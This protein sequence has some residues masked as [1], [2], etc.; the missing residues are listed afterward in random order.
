MERSAAV[1]VALGVIGAAI[2]AT[3]PAQAAQTDSATQQ[4]AGNNFFTGAFDMLQSNLDNVA[5][6]PADSLSDANVRAFLMLIRTGEG[7]AD[8]AGYSRLF[9]G[10]QFASYAD[11]PR[12]F[13]PFGST[14]STAAGAYQILARTWDEIAAKYAL[15]DFSPASQDLAAV[16]LIKRRGAL[17]DVLAGRFRTAIQKCANE[18]ASLPGSPYGQPTLSMS[19][20]ALVL[21]NNGGNATETIA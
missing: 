18:W 19:K 5:A 11:H 6:S 8:A 13:V 9:G 15:E 2:I 3:R 10:K 14:F 7:T 21:A 17:G 20:A 4:D 12:V 16:G 1:L